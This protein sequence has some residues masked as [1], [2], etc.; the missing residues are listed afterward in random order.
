MYNMIFITLG[1]YSREIINMFLLS[2]V[3]GLVEI[4][5]TWIFSDTINVVNVKLC[6]MILLIEL[7]LFIP[8]SMTLTIFQGHSTEQC[9][10]LLDIL[11]SYL[12]KL[13]L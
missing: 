9:W 11:C 13:K 4:I 8:P 10:L 7:H 1:V 2:Q 3:S 5:N 6:M 12:I